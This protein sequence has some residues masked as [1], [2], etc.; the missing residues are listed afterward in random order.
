MKRMRGSTA[1]L[2]AALVLCGLIAGP[3]A[4]AAHPRRAELKITR[5][6]PV[7]VH[8]SGFRRSERVRLVVRSAATRIVRRVTAGPRGAFT[9]TFAGIKLG[10]C[11][12]F[13]I[14]AT[15]TAGS[16]ASVMRHVALPACYPA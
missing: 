6:S 9:T 1:L 5:T 4:G 2:A 11:G 14:A 3:P 12:G 7:T 13:S 16:R 15:G 10:R 8:G